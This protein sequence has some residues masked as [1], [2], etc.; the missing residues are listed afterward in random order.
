MKNGFSGASPILEHHWKTKSSLKVKEKVKPKKPT[1][2]FLFYSL[3]FFSSFSRN[4]NR[5]KN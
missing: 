3:I 1:F 5:N 4:S 2:F